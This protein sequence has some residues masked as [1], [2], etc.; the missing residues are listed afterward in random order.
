MTGVSRLD[1][2]DRTAYPALTLTCSFQ[3]GVEKFRKS[4]HAFCQR[5]VGERVGEP[6]VSGLEQQ[7][8]GQ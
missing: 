2:G 3:A 4:L 7:P 5:I 1:V 6:C 8:N